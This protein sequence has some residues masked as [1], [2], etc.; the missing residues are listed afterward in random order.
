MTILEEFLDAG[1]LSEVGDGDARY[2]HTKGAAAAFSEELLKKP[3]AL[4]PTTLVSMDPDASF[5]DPAFEAPARN[6][7]E[8]WPTYK[9]A[10]TG[11]TPQRLLRAIMLQGLADA[12]DADVRHAAIITLTAQSYRPHAPLGAEA[13]VWDSL[14]LRFSQK[15]EEDAQTVWSAA[16]RSEPPSV[17]AVESK[18]PAIQ[19]PV[20]NMEQFTE[21]MAAAAGPNAAGNVVLKDATQNWPNSGQA[22]SWEFSPRAAKA[23]ADAINSVAAAISKQTVQQN[24]DLLKSFSELSS[25]L[26]KAVQQASQNMRQDASAAELRTAVLWWLEA[27]YSPTLLCSY[28]D[29]RPE[30]CVVATAFDLHGL[31]PVPR[32]A[33]VGYV[34]AE[35]VRR[36]VGAAESVPV[37]RFL[38]GL[39]EAP[40]K[41]AL[42]QFVTA[43]AQIT[44]GRASLLTLVDQAVHGHA[45]SEADL[46]DRLGI[47]FQTVV[48]V[49]ALALWLFRDLQAWKLVSELESEL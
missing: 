1:L 19:P 26:T 48:A 49:P 34:L 23:I 31:T 24:T 22:W 10:F 46:R 11:G 38:S 36:A 9:H 7:Q 30:A 47:D 4:I 41:A 5:T 21:R 44:P 42:K 33:S 8:K 45:V 13:E 17:P 14:L 6:L 39:A 27:S 15:V 37:G 16:S 28:R 25:A 43:P 18:N 32:P 2:E 40:N 20:I 29:L 12:G 3:A 35:A